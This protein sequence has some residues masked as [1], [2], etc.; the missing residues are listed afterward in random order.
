MSRAR[1]VYLAIN[2]C[3]ITRL[4]NELREKWPGKEYYI[5]TAIKQKASDDMA[6]GRWLFGCKTM[7]EMEE[8]KNRMEEM[9]KAGEVKTEQEKMM[10]EIS[11]YII[12]YIGFL[13]FGGQSSKE[14]IKQ[15]MENEIKEVLRHERCTPLIRERLEKLQKCIKKVSTSRIAAASP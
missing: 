13:G 5:L 4:A 6:I 12:H 7:E 11:M 9:I 3:D 14:D 8:M 10:P 2:L 15:T 1:E